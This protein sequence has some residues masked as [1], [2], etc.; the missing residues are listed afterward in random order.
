MKKRILVVDDEASITQWISA[1][2]TTGTNYEVDTSNDP[3]EARRRASTKKY[4][5]LISDMRMP[6]MAGDV[7][8]CHMDTDPET[9]QKT[10]N[11][12]KLLL[13]SGFLD[14]DSLKKQRNAMGAAEYLHKPFHPQELLNTVDSLLKED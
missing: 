6:Q 5:L 13:I 10:V 4:D 8:Y 12:P 7:L 14:E 2:L 1:V 9:G 11:R 3:L